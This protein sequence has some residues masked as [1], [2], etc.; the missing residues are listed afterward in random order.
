MINSL[1]E[2]YDQTERFDTNDGVD[3]AVDPAWLKVDTAVLVGERRNFI[4][5][6]FTADLVTQKYANNGDSLR[7]VKLDKEVVVI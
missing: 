6:Y 2:V 7:K 5:R 1:L 4:L 3:H